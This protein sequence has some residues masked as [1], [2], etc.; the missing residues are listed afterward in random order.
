MF[1]Q[2]RELKIN[3]VLKGKVPT[4]EDRLER[5]SIFPAKRESTFTSR[6]D[7]S[8]LAMCRR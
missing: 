5:L 2:F 8:G 4:S 1:Y 6:L 7:C 3:E